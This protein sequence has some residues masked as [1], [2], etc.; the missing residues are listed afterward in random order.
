M[1]CSTIIYFKGEIFKLDPLMEV[2]CF[3]NFNQKWLYPSCL[4]LGCCNQLQQ[5]GW[6]IKN[7]FLSLEA[8]SLRLGCQHGWVMVG[9]SSRL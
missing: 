9:P 2:K 4:S 7:K 1:S 8:G 6:F 3:R 5:T